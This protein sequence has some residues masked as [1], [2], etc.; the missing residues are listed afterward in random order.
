[1]AGGR[2]QSNVNLFEPQV[3]S[4]L[5]QVQNPLQHIIVERIRYMPTTYVANTVLSFIDSLTNQ[6]IGSIIVVQPGLDALASS[7]VLEWDTDG[8]PLSVGANLILGVL[9]GGVTGSL[10]VDCF[11][12]PLYIVTPYVAPMTAGFTK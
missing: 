7:Y 12:L 11:Q 10:E 2:A 3:G 5:V 6:S 4:I 8:F 1:M 9:S